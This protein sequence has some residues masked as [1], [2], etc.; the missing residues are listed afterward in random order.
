MFNNS[1]YYRVIVGAPLNQTNHKGIKNGGA[2]FKCDITED[3][4]CFPIEFD[5]KGKK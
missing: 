1:V 3:N 5:K 4:R 2:V